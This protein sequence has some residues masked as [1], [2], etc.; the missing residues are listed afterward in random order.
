MLFLHI[1][2]RV[3]TMRWKILLFVACCLLPLALT[4]KFQFQAEVSKLMSLII[5]SVY[6]TKEIFL[7]ELISNG[8]DALDKIRF[9]S[10]TETNAL[11]AQSELKISVRPDRNTSTLIITDTGIGMTKDELRNNLGTLAKSGTA[12]FVKAIESGKADL[13]LIGQFG[14]GFYSAFLVADRVRVVS[15]HNDEDRAY[16]WESDASGEFAI[17]EWTDD[18]RK[19]AG[20][21]RGTQITLFLKEDAK[22]YLEEKKLRDVIGKYSEFINFPIWMEVEKKEMI[23]VEVDAKDKKEKKE[24]EKEGEK[25]DEK[26][27]EKEDKKEDEES[28]VE[29]VEKSEDKSEEKAQ[30]KKRKKKVEKISYEWEQLN[31]QKPIWTRDSKEVKPSEYHAF[32]RVFTKDYDDPLAW[33][34]FKAEGDLSFRAIIFIPR[35]T[36]SELYQ[37]VR[38]LT[39]NVKLFV[40]KVFITDEM[41]ET[42]LPKWLNF[43]WVLVDSEDLPLNVSRETLQHNRMIRIIRKK[44]VSKSL[45]LLERLSREDPDKFKIVRKEFG[46]NLKLGAIEDNNSRPK[47]MKLLQFPSSRKTIDP[48]KNDY[49]G[50]EDYVSR[51][52]KGQD[53]IFF[54]TGR[55][56]KEI[57]ESPFV[58]RAL[59]RDYEVLFFDEPIDEYIVQSVLDFD[60]KPFQNIAKEGFKFGD[61]DPEDKQRE[62][63]Q[64]EEF[65]PLI[66]WLE[67]VVGDFIG[68]I[69]IT[70]RLTKSPCALVA[71][72]QGWSGN[73]ERI[74]SSQAM[75]KQ[76]ESTVNFRNYY[77]R[78][79]EINPNHPLMIGLLQHAKENKEEERDNDLPRVLFDI[80]LL[81]SGYEIKDNK[82]FSHRVERVMRR[83]L[84]V[85]L[86]V[87]AEVRE[88][89]APEHDSEEVK[90]EEVLEEYEVD[91]EEDEKKKEKPQEKSHDEL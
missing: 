75:Q 41:G 12:D 26:E 42:L 89:P 38:D 74:M 50:L 4:E 23:T 36:K 49:V 7:R 66:E 24:G 67:K 48:K 76:D 62:E 5:N 73:M 91:D 25:D 88:R 47:V 77:K 61:E 86:D 82:E 44:L 31:T 57:E 34:H 63:A 20:L 81:R 84:K 83:M 39:R 53:Q 37:A 79:L 15:K 78:I 11:D 28:D 69:A 16:V 2:T 51:M 30:P 8:S 90:E 60:G 54:L 6:K 72:T 10:L 46:I 17:N 22:E 55:N 56:T 52:K 87:E 14:V 3:A 21:G 32:Y 70:N 68:S 33:S 71:Q 29:D 59:V 64:K 85:D 58:E 43:L 9:I 40:K 65:K 45:E 1:L 13:S 27:D 80:A 35:H 19:D 18:E